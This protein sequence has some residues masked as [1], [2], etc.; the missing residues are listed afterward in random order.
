ML[1]ISV[2]LYTKYL[3]VV[4]VSENGYS[5]NGVNVSQERRIEA[6]FEAADRGASRQEVL[7]KIRQAGLTVSEV[8]DAVRGVMRRKGWA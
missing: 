2:S 3:E 4:K 5:A 1:S 7:E 8:R 6:I